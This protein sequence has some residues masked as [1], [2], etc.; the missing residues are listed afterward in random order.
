MSGTRSHSPK[1]QATDAAAIIVSHGQPSDPAP[2]EADLADLA[3][4]VTATLP[5]WRIA[6]AT[7]ATP[8]MLEKAARNMGHDALVYPLF[9]TDGWFTRTTLP[10]RLGRDD[11]HILAPL[12]ADAN[13][14]E[15]AY[16]WLLEQLQ[17]QNWQC[18]DTTLIIASHGSGKSR[19]PARDTE[20]FANALAERMTFS[21]LRIGYI[22]EPPYL[23]DVAFGSGS[24]AICLP[25]FAAA[26]GHVTDDIPEALNLAEF[27]G[28]RL[29]P[30]GTHPGIPALIATALRTGA[31]QLAAA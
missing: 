14:P 4:R 7:L 17:E 19:N 22:E 25:F 15:L 12:G 3:S 20:R 27:A 1:A 6:S 24:Q 9:M 2:A 23:G 26:G 5:G 21:A 16:N 30:I 8:G 31:N 18:R 10:K 13:L 29:P 28:L 11:A